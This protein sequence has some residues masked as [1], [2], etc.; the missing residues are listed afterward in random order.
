MTPRPASEFAGW[1][2]RALVGRRAIARSLAMLTSSTLW[3]TA[4]A[5]Q[6]APIAT[7]TATPT[8]T[9]TARAIAP[10]AERE[11]W[12]AVEIAGNRCGYQH[13]QMAV[14]EEGRITSASAVQFVLKRMNLE[15]KVR[16]A[17]TFVETKDH[18]PVSLRTV[19]ELGAEPA[20]A[21]YEFQPDGTVKVTREQSGRKATSVAKA[22]EGEWLT[23]A[24]AEAYVAAR[25]QAGAERF[26]VRTI[27]PTSGID[28]IV[29]SYTLVGKTELKIGTRSLPVWEY[30]ST[31]SMLPG[32][33]NRVFLDAAGDMVKSVTSLIGTDITT[34]ASTREEA[35]KA[36]DGP[37]ILLASFVTPD[38]Q[39][40]NPRT[41]ERASYIL[42]VPD[43]ELPDL[44]SAGSQLV[45]RLGP[46]R[47]RVTIQT[48]VAAPAPASD[49]T[50]PRYLASTSMINHEDER[51]R[52][53]A[54]R[55][56]RR[57]GDDPWD[58]AEACRAFVFKHIKNKNFGVAFATAS[59]VARN[60]SGDCSE[61]G[62]L[63]AAL[64]RANG[65]PARIVSGLVYADGLAGGQG[66]FGYHMWAQALL[67]KDG[68]K[69]WVD[70]DATLSARQR[71]DATHI[72]IVVTP[73]AEGELEG[74][75]VNIATIMG[76]LAISVERC[77]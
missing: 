53:L 26:E 75:M 70:F 13:D 41:S 1:F 30:T 68:Q 77:E 50:D 47:A 72:A 66:I 46:T 58:Q 29:V 27:D 15:V 55:A 61:H 34:V 76:R 7:P 9:P 6:P 54:A 20:I 23:P 4:S 33:K 65:I 2:G 24:A 43:G 35:L 12:Y 52:E 38:V 3:L 37:E 39:I 67:E 28:P 31:I 22:P 14:D 49:A 36:T 74:S 19:T 42:S 51:V 59:E 5:Q 45:E 32:V 57:A 56:V 44:P 71:H 60:A 21:E 25:Q 16:I 62:V 18:S 48:S 10:D 8:I 40:K 11:Q 63:L 64:L 73:L 69:R 17:S